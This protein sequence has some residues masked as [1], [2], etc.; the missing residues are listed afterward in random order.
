MKNIR[1]AIISD[2]KASH[3]WALE[4]NIRAIRFYERHVFRM[5]ADRKLEEDATEYLVR[6]VK[7]NK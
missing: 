5:T 3:L 6:L 1:K 7:R 2:L 4:K